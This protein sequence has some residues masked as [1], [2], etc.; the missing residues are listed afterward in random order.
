MAG[1]KMTTTTTT[2]TRTLVVALA[3][4]ACFAD[5]AAAQC[6]GNCGGFGF[7]DCFCDDV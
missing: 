3:A 5:L 6:S 2:T 1:W 7:I 4:A